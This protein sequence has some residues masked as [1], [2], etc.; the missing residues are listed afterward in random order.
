MGVAASCCWGCFA[1][2][3]TGAHKIDGIIMMGNDVDILK[4][5]LKTSVMKL[6]L[7]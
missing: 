1:A 2:G 3:G 6:K 7:D 4:Q 5:H